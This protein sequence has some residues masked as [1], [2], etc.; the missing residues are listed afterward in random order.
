LT[1]RAG[2]V[3]SSS[4]GWKGLERV[5][6]DNPTFDRF[7]ADMRALIAE[8]RHD[9][10]MLMQRGRA[11]LAELVSRDDWL[12]D[13]F[14]LVPQGAFKQYML[15]RE[16]GVDFSVLSVAWAPR[17]K[18]I[19]HDHTMW[20]MFGQLRGAESSRIYDMPIAGQPMTIRSEVLLR[21]GDTACISPA[22]GD[23]HDVENVDDGVSVSI[24]VY[25]GD[26][27]A[28]LDRRHRYDTATGQ[29]IPFESSYH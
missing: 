3:I 2:S 23:I 28:V 14:A 18:A 20:G 6:Q 11:R 5:L 21:P 13:R 29:M 26:L 12:P 8:V 17:Q 25:G 7:V 9:E 1:E 22:L 19:A 24:H 4:T 27:E 15:Y 10:A 16:D